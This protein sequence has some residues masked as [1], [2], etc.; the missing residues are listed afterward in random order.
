M[1]VGLV[2]FSSLFKKKKKRSTIQQKIASYV[3]GTDRP[4]YMPG[5]SI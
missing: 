3:W 4:G 1:F 5:P 2:K